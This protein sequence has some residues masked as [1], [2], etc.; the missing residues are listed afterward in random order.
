MA[1]VTLESNWNE[2]TGN[3]LQ[4]SRHS[5]HWTNET[6]T[7]FGGTRR[8][9]VPGTDRQ[10]LLPRRVAFA[11]NTD[12]Q[13]SQGNEMFRPAFGH[14]RCLPAFSRAQVAAAGK[15]RGFS[16]GMELPH[17]GGGSAGGPERHRTDDIHGSNVHEPSSV[18]VQSARLA[19]FLQFS[20]LSTIMRKVATLSC[21]RTTPINTLSTS[22]WVIVL[23]WSRFVPPIRCRPDSRRR[24][25]GLF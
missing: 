21:H 11:G 13:G 10:A 14:K 23:S 16:F 20:R 1:P 2:L 4:G 12:T 25:G 6:P 8:A 17:G 22:V 19:G 24:R 9:S 7:A 18:R 5:T 15:A 3:L